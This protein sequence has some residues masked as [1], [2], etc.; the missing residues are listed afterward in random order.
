MRCADEELGSVGVWSS[1]GHGQDASVSVL[2]GEVLISKLVAVDGLSTG[3][4]VVGEVTALT[5]EARDD[6]VEGAA[7]VAEA[8]VAGAEGAEVLRSLGHH[9]G[10]ELWKQITHPKSPNSKQS[11]VNVSFPGSSEEGFLKRR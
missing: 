8:L 5:H 9:V 11:E 4:V 3:S 6:A 10:T 2:Q 1:V 7:L